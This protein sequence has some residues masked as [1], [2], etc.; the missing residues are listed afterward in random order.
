VGEFGCI[1]IQVRLES[2][3]PIVRFVQNQVRITLT[4]G[5]NKKM[6]STKRLGR[7]IINLLFQGRRSEHFD[8]YPEAF[9]Y[10]SKHSWLCKLAE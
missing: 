8:H 1:D 10:A 9:L 5:A 4:M 7:I 3:T 2:S 6:V